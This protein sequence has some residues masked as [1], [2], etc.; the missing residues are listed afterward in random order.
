MSSNLIG[1]IARVGHMGP[2][3]K[4]YDEEALRQAATKSDDLIF[5]EE[6]KELRYILR[7]EDEEL[8]A[9]QLKSWRVSMEGET[10]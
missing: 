8:Y 9:Q 7:T 6:T 5:D 2:T 1:V 10:K 4:V 3:G